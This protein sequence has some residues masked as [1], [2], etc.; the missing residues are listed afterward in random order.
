MEAA[1][2]CGM[3]CSK[4]YSAQQEIAPEIATDCFA[5]LAMT[6]ARNDSGHINL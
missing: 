1:S 2:F 6:L 3:Q 5:L 4:R